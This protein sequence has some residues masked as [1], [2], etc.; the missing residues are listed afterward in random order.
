VG[1]DQKIAEML[2]EG[3]EL[4]HSLSDSGFLNLGAM[5]FTFKR[6]RKD[7]V[8]KTIFGLE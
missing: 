1:K 8:V 3:W 2:S 7:P 4:V 6:N 5:A